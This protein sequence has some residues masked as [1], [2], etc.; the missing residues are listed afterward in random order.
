[1]ISSFGKQN[2]K[3]WKP[4]SIAW[5]ER[6]TSPSRTAAVANRLAAEDNSNT[7]TDGNEEN[8][9]GKL[10]ET[11]YSDLRD[12]TSSLPSTPSTPSTPLESR[13]EPF[14][15]PHSSNSPGNPA[16]STWSTVHLRLASPERK[17]SSIESKFEQDIKQIKA[18]KNRDII[19]SEKKEKAKQIQNRVSN[20]FF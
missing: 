19:E 14:E 6:K 17:K 7:E 15:S 5:E 18:K 20:Y 4:K 2:E 3:A 8:S 9:F 11:S 12:S 1:M 13:K 16:W 10:P